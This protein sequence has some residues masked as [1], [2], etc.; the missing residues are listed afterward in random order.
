M[1]RLKTPIIGISLGDVNGIAPE[2][3]MKTL[4]DN[5]LTEFC[6]PVVY[7]SPKVFSYYKKMLG[8]NEFNLFISK[9]VEQINP[10][11]ANVVVCWEEEI[12]IK[13]GEVTEQA[14][15]YALR[16]LKA[17]VST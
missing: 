6:I 8:L 4:S 14:G 1:N 5:R 11:R 12:E 15:K 16:S 9:T 13:P 3:I 2:V 7:G 10:K 17:V